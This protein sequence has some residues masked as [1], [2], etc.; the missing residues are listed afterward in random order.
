MHDR[1][2]EHTGTDDVEERGPEA[3]EAIDALTD[4]LERLARSGRPELV[5]AVRRLTQVAGELDSHGLH[6][7]GDD[8]AGQAAWIALQMSGVLGVLVAELERAHAKPAGTSLDFESRA[9]LLCADL[10]ELGFDEHGRWEFNDVMRA[11][12]DA[13]R[14]LTGV[15]EGPYV[16]DNE[17]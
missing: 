11:Q 2:S 9:R 1:M 13:R 8:A 6:M 7:L 17:H 5:T 10:L 14:I 12:H 15:D 16:P 4:R 3:A